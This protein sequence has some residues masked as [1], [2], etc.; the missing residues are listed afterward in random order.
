MG[1]VLERE[2]ALVEPGDE[3]IRFHEDERYLVVVAAVCDGRYAVFD[4]EA[5]ELTPFNDRPLPQPYG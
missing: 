3:P 2:G 1:T 4:T 5:M